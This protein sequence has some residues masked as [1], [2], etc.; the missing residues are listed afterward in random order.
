MI[1][2]KSYTTIHKAD[3]LKSSPQQIHNNYTKKWLSD[4]GNVLSFIRTYLPDHITKQL[5][6]NDLEF[7]SESFVDMHFRE[8]I[9]D[10]VV[11]IKQGRR[12][13]YVYSIIEIK[14]TPDKL[15]A[16]QLMSYV[17][18]A[19]LRY[20][21]NR[22]T[23]PLP[24]IYPFI[25]YHGETKFK[26]ALDFLD[27]VDA[28]Q[29]DL[30]KYLRGNFQLIDLNTVTD[31]ALINYSEVL[32][33]L[34]L[35]CLKHIKD[36]NLLDF[37]TGNQH[38]DKIIRLFHEYIEIAGEENTRLALHYLCTAGKITDKE[39]L[40][41]FLHKIKPGLEDKVVNFIQESFE[42]GIEQGMERGMKRGREDAE[43]SFIQKLLRNNSTPQFIAQLLGCRI[44]KVELLAQDLIETT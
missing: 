15:T 16:A 13:I 44:E 39:K 17:L 31:E 2:E 42:Q 23:K 24:M 3:N 12:N 11:K 37:L 29:A 36:K 35:L 28:S 27:L 41:T 34:P 9:V 26:Y 4:K 21:D 5:T 14:S 1:P 6:V 18:K 20:K 33:S 40:A 43:N 7:V 22:K 32:L 8:N 10:A 30:D 25:L 38:G 19:M